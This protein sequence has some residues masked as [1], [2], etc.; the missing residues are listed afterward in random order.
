MT[1]ELVAAANCY[2]TIPVT[3]AQPHNLFVVQNRKF[4]TA[5][6]WWEP[7]GSKTKIGWISAGY[8]M[9]TILLIRILLLFLLTKFL[10]TSSCAFSAFLSP[11]SNE[12]TASLRAFT[13]SAGDFC[14]F[15]NNG[16]IYWAWTS[17]ESYLQI[18][19]RNNSAANDKSRARRRYCQ[20]LGK[21]Y[22]CEIIWSA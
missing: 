4:H 2:Y 21:R 20:I 3:V 8:S 17:S 1:P 12:F 15:P 13:N 5:Y 11:R 14:D 10:L 18:D 16:I 7:N 22:R 19:W 6:F 9:L